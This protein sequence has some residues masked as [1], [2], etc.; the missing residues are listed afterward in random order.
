MIRTDDHQAAPESG[1]KETEFQPRPFLEERHELIQQFE[2]DYVKRLLTLTH[3]NVSEAARRAGVSRQ[4]LYGLFKRH[5]I[6]PRQF[7]RSASLS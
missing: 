4:A 3:G 5:E 2:R 1:A 7:S 6:D